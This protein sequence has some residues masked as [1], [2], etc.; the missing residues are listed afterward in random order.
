MT[1]DCPQLCRGIIHKVRA[2]EFRA[3]QERQ[4]GRPGIFLCLEL[5]DVI[6]RR[7]RLSRFRNAVSLP[8]AAGLSVDGFNTD[9]NSG[10]CHLKA[11]MASN[12][13]ILHPRYECIA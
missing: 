10:L 12:E 9:R 6:A 1:V 4:I 13:A 3:D 8:I 5:L 7:Y 2:Y 11:N